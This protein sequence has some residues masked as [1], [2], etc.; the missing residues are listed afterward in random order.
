MKI[1]I[2]GAHGQLGQDMTSLCKKS[3]HDVVP[4]GSRE[5]DIRSYGMVYDRIQTQKPE[6][7]IN[8]AAY[9]AVDQAETDWEEAFLVNGIG[10]KNLTLAANAA[11]AILV[12]YSTDYVFNGKSR[13]PYTLADHP[14]PLSRYGQSKLLGEQQVMRHA[15]HYFLIR[16]S[17]VFG[18]GK[19]NF[20]KK[21]LEWSENRESITVVD[22]QIS[23]PTY[24]RDLAQ[25]TLDIIKTG[26]YGLYHC[27]NTGY[28]SRFDYAAYVLQQV[29][30]AG[31]IIPGKSSDFN[32]P[33]ARPQF[34]ALDN[35]G[36]KHAIGYDMPSWQDAINRFLHEIGRI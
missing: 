28:C 19:S 16:V 35:F 30:W 25:A 27:T 21:I 6:I 3:G 20:V 33:A 15:N 11:G 24:T 32:S 1:L 2:T 7:V 8:C 18:S 9:N 23:S 12:H 17:W 36:I 10:P 26:Q 29:G 14:C 34:S 31:E 5:L 13:R 22:D 4:Y